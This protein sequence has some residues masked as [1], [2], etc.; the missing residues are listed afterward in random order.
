MGGIR[1]IK[2]EYKRKMKAWQNKHR[3]MDENLLTPHP[4]WLAGKGNRLHG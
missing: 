4:K 1:K 3:C 2:N